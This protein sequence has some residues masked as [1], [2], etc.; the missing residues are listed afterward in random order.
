MAENNKRQPLSF[1]GTVGAAVV[2]S[3][4]TGGFF[5]GLSLLMMAKVAGRALEG[6]GLPPEGLP[7]QG[8]TGNGQ[9]F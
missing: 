4:I 2:S 1:W 9:P 5:Y 8:G 6:A 3:A 7:A